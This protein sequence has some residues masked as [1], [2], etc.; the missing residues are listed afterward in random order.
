M[1]AFLKLEQ[2]ANAELKVQSTSCWF[3]VSEAQ[4]P[5]SG[6]KFQDFKVQ[7]IL[8]NPLNP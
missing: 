3:Q 1:L 4:V 8:K 7:E 2:L 6:F 5:V